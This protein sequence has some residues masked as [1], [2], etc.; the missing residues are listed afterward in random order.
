MKQIVEMDVEQEQGGD[1]DNSIPNFAKSTKTQCIDYLLTLNDPEERFYQKGALDQYNLLTLQIWAKKA[2]DSREFMVRQGLM[3]EKV[4]YIPKAL[5]MVRPP[6]AMEIINAHRA[7]ENEKKAE[8]DSKEKEKSN[9]EKD[10]D[11]KDSGSD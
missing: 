9:L 1:N 7:E 10:G 8:A 2:F 3:D 4:V 6:T 5:K 11:V